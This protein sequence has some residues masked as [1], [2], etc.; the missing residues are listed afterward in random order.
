MV[1]AHSKINNA[2]HRSWVLCLSHTQC[3]RAQA[4]GPSLWVPF[5]VLR[6]EQARQGGWLQRLLT[7]CPEW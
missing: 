2:L 1:P 7:P 3:G 5:L 4:S 6:E